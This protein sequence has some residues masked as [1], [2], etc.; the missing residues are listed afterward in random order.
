MDWFW[1][2]HYPPLLGRHPNGEFSRDIFR[3]C[4]NFQVMSP[5]FFEG[6]GGGKELSDVSV[7][8]ELGIRERRNC[9]ERRCL[10]VLQLYL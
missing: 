6:V 4:G 2:S 10:I 3:E 7:G 5:T 1:R 8:I 9:S